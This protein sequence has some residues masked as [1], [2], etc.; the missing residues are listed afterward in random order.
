MIGQ[1]NMPKMP[2]PRG[3]SARIQTLKNLVNLV[4]DDLSYEIITYIINL[5]SK[6]AEEQKLA[7]D[8]N[9]SYTQ[10]RQSLITMEKHGLLLS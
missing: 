4:Y 9:L 2:E 7:E 8:L 10:V 5:N 3:K 6:E 1:G